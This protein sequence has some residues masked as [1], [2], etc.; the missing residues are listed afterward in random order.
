VNEKKVVEFDYKSPKN[1]APKRKSI[2]PHLMVMHHGRW[3]FY[4]TDTD[5]RRLTPFAFVRVSNLKAT[6]RKFTTEPE[7]H[8]G[9]LLALSFGSVIS[10]DEPV[11]V[12]L[13]FDAEVVER[14]KESVWHPGQKLEDLE[15][16]Q[17]RLTLRLSSTLEIQPWIL[18]WGPKVKVIAPGSLVE[19]IAA[20]AKKMAA[21]YGS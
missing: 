17:A 1:A 14:L 7:P 6:S 11:D 16:G 8:P 20:N 10:T 21:R 3:Y 2:E 9:D 4:G 18:G 5:S 13:E 15:G 19:S 12:V